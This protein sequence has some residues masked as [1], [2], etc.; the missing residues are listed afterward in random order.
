[1][2]RKNF[3]SYYP[4]DVAMYPSSRPQPTSWD[5]MK[6]NAG[7]AIRNPHPLVK[8]GA[9]GLGGY[10]L[11]KNRKHIGAAIDQG[12]DLAAQGRDNVMKK[13]GTD[14]YLKDSKIEEKKGG[15]EDKKADSAT[16]KNA[17]G[18]QDT[19]N[20]DNINKSN[21]TKVDKMLESHLKN[22]QSSGHNMNDVNQA[23]I[24]KAVDSNLKDTQSSESDINDVNQAQIDNAV[25]SNLE[26]STNDI[27]EM[28]A[29]SNRLAKRFSEQNDPMGVVKSQLRQFSKESEIK[30]KALM[31]AG[32]AAL[33]LTATGAGLVGKEI[34]DGNLGVKT[35]PKQTDSLGQTESEENL[36]NSLE[37]A[38][39][40]NKIQ[41]LKS[42]LI[43]DN[44]GNKEKEE[45][46]K[47]D[48]SSD[49][50]EEMELE[51]T[52]FSLSNFFGLGDKEN[53]NNR[54]MR[55]FGNNRTTQS[56]NFSNE[57]PDHVKVALRTYANEDHSI[58]PVL[59]RK[60]SMNLEHIENNFSDKPLGVALLRY[61][62]DC[63]GVE[64]YFS[65]DSGKSDAKSKASTALKA[66]GAATLLGGA[67]YGAHKG[68]E[69]INTLKDEITTHKGNLNVAKQELETLNSN[70]EKL[71]AELKTAKANEAP[72]LAK[73]YM[74][75]LQKNKDYYEK[76]LKRLEE[77]DRIEDNAYEE[78]I[79]K[80][81]NDLSA[82][83]K[84]IDD[85][86][87]VAGDAADKYGN[88]INGRVGQAWTDTKNLAS[89]K[90]QESAQ[91]GGLGWLGNLFKSGAAKIEDI[92]EGN[93]ELSEADQM[94]AAIE[95]SRQ[96]GFLNDVASGKFGI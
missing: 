32:A 55:Y 24:D 14:K 70:M 21:Q 10:A 18:Q 63:K 59:Q 40:E 39:P 73:Q 86:K 38:E 62:K 61:Y 20:I 95:F 13:F 94:R 3:D 34:L 90:L 27:P 44:K 72:E 15:E 6:Y 58:A 5:R 37:I 16:A 4:P 11:F 87:T 74:E 88:T 78:R 53:M 75:S 66:L 1:M 36:R 17:Q 65:K 43:G 56:Y 67:G 92:K 35:L 57:K 25:D 26:D 54:L 51:D 76:E 69:Y 52:N 83:N 46:I 33:G 9:V 79:G 12:K 96:H 89:D 49:K 85:L 22:N 30:K 68:N 2:V 50:G 71:E 64:T 42:I 48:D 7:Y 31:A 41:T 91:T 23:Q 28:I 8:A 84:K 19:S 77:E 45:E 29:F 93:H 81:T 47:D 60:S 82:A 80:L